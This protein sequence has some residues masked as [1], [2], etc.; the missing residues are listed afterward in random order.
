MLDVDKDIRVE[1]R[2]V[3]SGRYKASVTLIIG[4][5][6]QVNGFQI[7]QGDNGKLYVVNPH[8]INNIYNK[9]EFRREINYKAT[10][11]LLK[12]A[13]RKKLVDKIIEAYAE[14]IDELKQAMQNTKVA[15]QNITCKT[16]HIV[17]AEEIE[18]EWK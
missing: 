10:A 4:D 9:V 11:N 2:I 5:F 18:K 3:T 15:H 6:I 1:V 16:K 17:T 13:D 12:H 8:V 7:T 14:K